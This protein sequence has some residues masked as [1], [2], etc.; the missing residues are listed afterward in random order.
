M[1]SR[2]IHS[3]PRAAYMPGSETWPEQETTK[4]KGG[5]DAGRDLLET[6]GERTSWCL[7][8]TVQQQPRQPKV[9]RL[10]SLCHVVARHGTGSGPACKGSLFSTAKTGRRLSRRGGPCCA[11]ADQSS[12][13]YSSTNTPAQGLSSGH[14]VAP[15][16][17]RAFPLGGSGE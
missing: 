5:Q 1:D 15:W 9:S 13:F 8:H 11:I 12:C 7:G 3:F 2:A 17:L 4:G 6:Q 16:D 14:L 10:Y